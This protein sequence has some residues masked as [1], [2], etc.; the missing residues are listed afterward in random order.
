MS[1]KSLDL[2]T[3]FQLISDFLR[4]WVQ[5]SNT[6]VVV[7]HDVKEAVWLGDRILVLSARP[8]RL[9]ECFQD[10]ISL[11]ARMDGEVSFRLEEAITKAILKS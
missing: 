3:R 5:K 10:D 1:P 4:W 8:A 11:E 2:K 7:T 9:I 6:V